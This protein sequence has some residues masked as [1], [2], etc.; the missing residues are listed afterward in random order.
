M[1][2]TGKAIKVVLFVELA[3]LTAVSLLLLALTIILLFAAGYSLHLLPASAE[4]I[5]RM[6]AVAIAFG[7]G[8]QALIRCV[9]TWYDLFNESAGPQETQRQG[10]QI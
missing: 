7:I 4:S 8:C 9:K 1:A 3:V 10:K 6:A 5:G 2:K